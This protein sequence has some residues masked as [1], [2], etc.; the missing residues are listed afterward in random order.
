MDFFS[1]FSLLMA[2]SFTLMAYYLTTKAYKTCD[3]IIL[4]FNKEYIRIEDE[5]NRLRQ[6]ID[7]MTYNKIEAARTVEDVEKAY[8]KIGIK[9]V[10]E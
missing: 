9:K 2:T 4:E 7:D 10:S 1:V 8:G 6:M 5:N 3:K